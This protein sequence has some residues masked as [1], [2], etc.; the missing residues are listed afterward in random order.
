MK[1]VSSHVVALL[2]RS[3]G[4]P[5]GE[6]VPLLVEVDDGALEVEVEC[7]E[8]VVDAFRLGFGVR[9]MMVVISGEVALA[10]PLV[11]MAEVDRDRG[12]AL[13]VGVVNE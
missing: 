8:N 2:D 6:E 10:G 11:E 13:R 9:D 12:L 1:S 4:S 7:R 3:Y 5:V